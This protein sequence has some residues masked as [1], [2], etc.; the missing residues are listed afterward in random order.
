MPGLPSWNTNSFL[1][2]LPFLSMREQTHKRKKGAKRQ[3]AVIIKLTRNDPNSYFTN[4]FTS[5]Q[6][7]PSSFPTLPTHPASP[8]EQSPPLQ[9][10]SPPAPLPPFHLHLQ[11]VITTLQQH[12]IMNNSAPRAAISSQEQKALHCSLRKIMELFVGA[13]DAELA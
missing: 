5:A 3:P 9:T 4:Q 13:H 6:P 2:P 11:I 12:Q 1:I 8:P 10:S 7:S